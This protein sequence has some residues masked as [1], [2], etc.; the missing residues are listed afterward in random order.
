MD[1]LHATA[2]TSADL[3]MGQR[4]P[5][6]VL[7]LSDG[8]PVSDLT[9]VATVTL[10]DGTTATPAMTLIS[11]GVYEVVVLANTAG[12]WIA[13]VAATGYGTVPFAATV[14]ALVDGT[15][16]PD[17]TATLDYLTGQGDQSWSEPEVENALAAE[18]AAQR[19]VCRIP[20]N[21]DA[22]LREALLRRVAC[23]LARR[24]LPL[25]MQQGD[26]DQ[27]PVAIGND[28]E[29]KRLEKPWRRRPVG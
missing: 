8:W 20:A 3:T 6:R 23:N 10:P 26:A 28:P 29:V 19:R 21:Y 24:A 13:T 5:L 15:G 18:T 22:D 7:A 27:G 9:T 12:R 25:S 17:L 11:A 4:W 16:M 14:A 2:P 1:L